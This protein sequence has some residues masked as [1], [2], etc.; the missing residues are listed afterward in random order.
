MVRA[1]GHMSWG[2]GGPE[3]NPG[4]DQKKRWIWKIN[5]FEKKIKRD[6]EDKIICKED[7]R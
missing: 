5:I 6:L 3:I 4:E 1:G 2:S 7:Q